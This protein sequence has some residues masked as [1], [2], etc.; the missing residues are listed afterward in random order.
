MNSAF[1]KAILCAIFVLLLAA[2]AYAETQTLEQALAL[3]Y[4]TNPGLQ[5]ER[6]KLRAVD[7]QVSR[8][9]SGWRPDISAT[10]DDGKSR[11]RLD[12]VGFL[13]Q[14]K[15]LSPLDANLNVTQP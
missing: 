14:E 7:E 4:Q 13:S 11:Q 10:A 8:A 9:L 6:A 1:A 3:A 5:A 12:G 15:N 2:P